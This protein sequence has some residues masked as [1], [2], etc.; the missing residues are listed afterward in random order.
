MLLDPGCSGTWVPCLGMYLHPPLAGRA[1]MPG[2]ETSAWKR[3]IC[4]HMI[5][6]TISSTVSDEYSSGMALWSYSSRVGL[7]RACSA[8]VVG[9]TSV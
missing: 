6:G 7:C 8:A 3:L 2:D 4:L 9:N 5:S 1:S